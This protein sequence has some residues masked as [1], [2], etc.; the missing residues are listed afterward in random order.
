[1]LVVL[2]LALAALWSRPR[3]MCLLAAASCLLPLL[4]VLNRPHLRAGLAM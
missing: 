1:V 3:W 2:I 4:V